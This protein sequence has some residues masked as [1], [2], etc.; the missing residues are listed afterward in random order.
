MVWRQQ[1]LISQFIDVLGENQVDATRAA[2][3]IFIMK[4]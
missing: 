2:R 1:L 3:S 4:Q